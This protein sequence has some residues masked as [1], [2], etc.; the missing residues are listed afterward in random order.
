M[1]DV[2]VCVP[3]GLKVPQRPGFRVDGVSVRQLL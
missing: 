2:N 3:P 1:S